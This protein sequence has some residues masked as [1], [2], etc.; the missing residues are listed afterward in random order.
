MKIKEE[1]LREIIQRVGSGMAYHQIAREL[2][3]S[4]TTV[5]YWGKQGYREKIKERNKVISNKL[6]KEGK[7][8]AQIHP[9]KYREWYRKYQR[10]RYHNDPAFRRKVL[11]A[12]KRLMEKK[13]QEKRTWAQTH[14]EEY[15]E[16]MRNYSREKR[17]KEAVIFQ[18][19]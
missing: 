9:E 7:S 11:D 17:K 2:N 4:V 5:L 18:Q 15:K 1:V 12:N 3:L 13:R 10:E 16:Y 8:W 19:L 14:P 6:Y